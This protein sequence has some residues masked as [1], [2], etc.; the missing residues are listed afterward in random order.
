MGEGRGEGAPEGVPDRWRVWVW[1]RVIGLMVVPLSCSCM[2]RNKAP[3]GA[4]HGPSPFW[5]L[6]ALQAYLSKYRV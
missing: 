5:N 4:Q 3:S 2:P 1:V 6:D